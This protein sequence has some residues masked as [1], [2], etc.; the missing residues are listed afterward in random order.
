ATLKAMANFFEEVLPGLDHS[1]LDVAQIG[2]QL[3]ALPPVCPA[4]ARLRVLRTGWWLGTVRNGR[5]EPAHSLAMAIDPALA[6]QRIDLASDDPV[7][8][9]ERSPRG[10]TLRSA[11]GDV[12]GRVLCDGVSRC[13]GLRTRW[14]T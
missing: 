1:R 11:G 13:R 6:A 5:F 10:D 4:L 12:W 3:Q 14:L 2:D 8:E 9:V 7:G